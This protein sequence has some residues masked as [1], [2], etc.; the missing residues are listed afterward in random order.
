MIDFGD[1]T[2]DRL[3]YRPAKAKRQYLEVN[4]GSN[5]RNYA[6]RELSAL[7]VC[8]GLPARSCSLCLCPNGGTIRYDLEYC[9]ET[10]AQRNLIPY[11]PYR[12]H[13]RDVCHPHDSVEGLP[14][15][16]DSAADGLQTD[17]GSAEKL[18]AVW[19][20]TTFAQNSLSV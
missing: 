11:Q 20:V 6:E 7:I 4:A 5:D 17:R 16:Q 2:Q 10:S 18:G 9:S 12:K 19:M 13:L 3:C 14:V 15:E 8:I 1:M